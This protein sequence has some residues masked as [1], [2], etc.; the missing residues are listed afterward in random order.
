[1]AS[2]FG[3][4]RDADWRTQTR[5]ASQAYDRGDMTYPEFVAEGLAIPVRA[6]GREIQSYIPDFVSDT[7]N[8][9]L[10]LPGPRMLTQFAKQDPGVQRAIRADEALTESYPEGYP[11]VKNFAGNV[12]TVADVGMG[13][14][15][16][17][18]AS[19]LSRPA[20]SSGAFATGGPV[21]KVGHYNKSE[22]PLSDFEQF[23]MEN[24]DIGATDKSINMYKGVK[25]NVKFFGE[26]L[27]NAGRMM[28]NPAT[29]ARYTEYGIPAVYDR[30][31]EAYQKAVKGGDPTE[32][33]S[34]LEIAHNQ[35]QAASN[36]EKQAGHISKV[37]NVPGEFAEAATDI[38][39]PKTY[40]RPTEY[41]KDWFHEAVSPGATFGGFDLKDSQFIQNHI[42]KVW[43]GKKGYNP[44]KTYITVKTPR[45]SITGN[46]FRDVLAN[47]TSVTKITNLFKGAESKG[48]P[49]LKTFNSVDELEKALKGLET[50]NVYT[51]GEKTG[52]V[53]K[54][55]LGRDR[56]APIKVL[57]SD[58]TGVWVTITDRDAVIGTAKTE[59]GV[60]MIVK[61]DP[62]GNLTGV[63]SDAHNFLEE[64]GIKGTNIRVRNRLMEAA[65]QDD[66]IAVTPPMQTNVVSV[67][68]EG[69]FGDMAEELR[70][71]PKETMRVPE[72]ARQSEAEGLTQP[73]DRVIEAGEMQAS[74]GEIARQSVPV[75]QNILLTEA[76]LGNY[77]DDPFA[78][79]PDLFGGL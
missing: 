28:F 79:D 65:L 38:S 43:A 7:V 57:K 44:D 26:L 69:K 10:D 73:R 15:P 62:E 18:R 74:A 9:A 24:Y 5:Q 33:K 36:I 56:K 34:A 12:A 47:N 75:A 64:F 11:R 70:E 55:K 39:S 31:Y 35:M 4:D 48:A 13:A 20:E 8:Y 58:D 51:K 40:F 77:E 30:M 23:M 76:M 68:K 2:L 50:D 21:Y 27:S 71:A 22:V 42:E 67:S 52:Q 25:G 29:R 72:R 60:N 19:L 37:R 54:D 46:H 32:I 66:V 41:G 17:A 45:S 14:M 59:G 3:I 6:L 16:L 63:M 53:K 49:F 1:M 61:V 78:Y